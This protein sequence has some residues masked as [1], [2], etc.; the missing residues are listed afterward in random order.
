MWRAGLCLLLVFAAVSCG[1]DEQKSK[2]LSEPGERVYDLSGKIVGRDSGDNTVRVD[3]GPI[4]GFMEGMT[5][6]FSVR[7]AEVGEL[8]AD[9]TAIAAKL[10]VTERAYWL[11]EIRQTNSR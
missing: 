8:P 9:G 11:T 7:G 4:P 2:P 5:M 3:H 10:H 1:S 6:D